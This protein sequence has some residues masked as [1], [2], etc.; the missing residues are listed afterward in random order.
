MRD[1]VDMLEYENKLL[2]EKNAE[3]ESE[4][5][6]VSKARDAVLSKYS[7]VLENIVGTLDPEVKVSKTGDFFQDATANVTVIARLMQQSVS[8]FVK[9]IR[10]NE[11]KQKKQYKEQGVQVGSVSLVS[12]KACYL[13]YYCFVV[14]MSLM[15]NSILEFIRIAWNNEKT[16]QESVQLMQYI[17]IWAKV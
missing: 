16:T 9:Y 17:S 14:V 15:Q 3:L 4:I 12:N 5:S 7:D 11:E 6:D 2:E 8:D 10:G 1:K 13:V